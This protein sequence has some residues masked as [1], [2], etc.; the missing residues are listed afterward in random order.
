MASQVRQRRPKSLRTCH[1]LLTDFTYLVNF[2]QHENTKK[3]VP[4]SPKKLNR[5]QTAQIQSHRLLDELHTTTRV[6]N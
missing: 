1:G 2:L 5:R 6:I 4:P 3:S